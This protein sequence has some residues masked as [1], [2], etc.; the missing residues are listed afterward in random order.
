MN[1]NRSP[2][3]CIHQRCIQI[4]VRVIGTILFTHF[5]FYRSVSRT[6]E[7]VFVSDNPI[8]SHVNFHHHENVEQLELIRFDNILPKLTIICSHSLWIT[9]KIFGPNV[10]SRYLVYYRRT[11]GQNKYSLKWC[12]TGDVSLQV[13]PRVPNNEKLCV[14]PTETCNYLLPVE[15]YSNQDTYKH[16]CNAIETK[17]IYVFL[18]HNAKNFVKLME[19]KIVHGNVATSWNTSRNSHE[20]YIF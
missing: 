18:S 11:V 4:E 20:L 13:T 19:L 9:V 8:F 3:N 15:F 16:W 7:G 6:E 5:S 10:S 17:I 2:Y 14:W 12:R 1:L